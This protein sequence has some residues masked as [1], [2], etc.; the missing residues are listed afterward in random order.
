[1]VGAEIERTIKS[2]AKSMIP[3]LS[4]ELARMRPQRRPEVPRHHA[5]RQI[6]RDI[7]CQVDTWLSTDR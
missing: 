4:S 5:S 2:P 7:L 1:M 6:I 3:K